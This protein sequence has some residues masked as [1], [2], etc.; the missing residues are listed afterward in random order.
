M[1]SLGKDAQD[2]RLALVFNYAS[3]GPIFRYLDNVIQPGA[4]MK[5]WMII[6]SIFASLATALQH[7]HRRGIVHLYDLSFQIFD[8]SKTCWDLTNP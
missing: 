6:H 4:L 8:T 1:E 7:I 3:E 5:N 2:E